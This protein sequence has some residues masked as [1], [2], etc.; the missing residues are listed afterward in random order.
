MSLASDSVE[1]RLDSLERGDR[2]DKL[3]AELKQKAAGV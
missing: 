2:V 1:K 3:L